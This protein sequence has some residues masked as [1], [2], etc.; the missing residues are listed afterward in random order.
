MFI[1]ED[2]NMKFYKNIK[3]YSL[4]LILT[5]LF[6]I[7]CKDEIEH[8]PLMMTDDSLEINFIIPEIEHILTRGDQNNGEKLINSLTILIFNE[9]GN[10]IVQRYDLPSSHLDNIK[11]QILKGNTFSF[12][13]PVEINVKEEPGGVIY[14]LANTISK[15]DNEDWIEDFTT[16]TDK[17]IEDLEKITVDRHYGIDNGFIMTGKKKGFESREVNIV[18]KRSM[19]KISVKDVS[20][21]SLFSL[22]GYTVVN[23]ASLGYIAAAQLED[24]FITEN[25]EIKVTA[26][27]VEENNSVRW[28][29]YVLPT[30]TYSVANDI[31]SVTT[32]IIIEGIYN[33]EKGYYAIPLYTDNEEIYKNNNGDKYL[34]ILPNY[35]YEIELN[36][37]KGP[38]YSSFKEAVDNPENPENPEID[39]SVSVHD[40][41]TAITS[42]ISDGI[43]ELGVTSEIEMPANS[44]KGAEFYVKCYS[45]IDKEESEEK[46]SNRIP[47]AEIISG[48]D[49]IEIATLYNGV[50][51]PHK[52]NSYDITN[53]EFVSEKDNEAVYWK[54]AILYNKNGVPSVDREAFVRITWC[55]LERFV[56][57]V[58]KSNN[59]ANQSS[60]LI[61]ATL[62]IVDPANQTSFGSSIPSYFDYIQNN[63]YGTKDGEIKG[64]RIRNAGFHFPMPVMNKTYDKYLEYEYEIDFS[65]LPN[66]NQIENVIISVSGD[67]FFK[68]NLVWEP[69][70]NNYKGWLK[71]EDGQNNSYEYALGEITFKIE[72]NKNSKLKEQSFTFDLYHTGFFYD[73]GRLNENFNGLF[74]YEVVPIKGKDNETYYWLDRNLLAAS[75]LMSVDYADKIIGDSKSIGGFFRIS[76]YDKSTGSSSLLSGICP[77]GY[78][79]PSQE[80]WNQLEL[81]T[82]QIT[83]DG[84]DIWST[85]IVSEDSRAGKIYFPKGRCY[86]NDNTSDLDKIIDK[87]NFGEI[88]TGYYWTSEIPE[89]EK[90]TGMI[91]KGSTME[92]SSFAINQYKMNV[93]C[94]ADYE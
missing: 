19:G 7:S 53:S 88:A 8:Q 41:A 67:D 70:N 74:Y 22:E 11:S 80:E 82:A 92:F 51:I 87:A 39:Y 24:K 55:G 54:F 48:E 28:D 42:M 86:F 90:Q 71:L 89:E 15:E 84:E 77:P 66:K 34:D 27:K 17:S 6:I 57:V 30:K 49:W 36:N 85:F 59:T 64:E 4:M 33:G 58:Y 3:I 68:D 60:N 56:K 94:I 45:S 40:Q 93:R 9:T 5:S 78:H 2:K 26:G 35:W 12:K 18:L 10:K 13:M 65:N 16:G 63:L 20:N 73:C 69:T 81:T 32:F 29:C 38:G 43:R 52:M 1:K 21:S 25:A 23:T 76:N 31:S 83:Q 72:Y 50:E 61:E 14:A 46:E 47:N 44:D 37:I 79:I 91:L 75:S 62:Y